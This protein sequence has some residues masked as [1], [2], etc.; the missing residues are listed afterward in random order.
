VVC[1]ALRRTPATVLPHELPWRI[2]TALTYRRAGPRGCFPEGASCSFP[3][4]LMLAPEA[5]SA[6]L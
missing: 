2:E 3:E 6:W 5:R 1:R 4:G